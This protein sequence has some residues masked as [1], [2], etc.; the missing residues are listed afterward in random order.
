MK[1]PYIEETDERN[2]QFR[3]QVVREQPFRSTT[4][5]VCQVTD[6]CNVD[7]Q[8]LPCAPLLPREE[9][10]EP[11]VENV[12]VASAPKQKRRRLTKKTPDPTWKKRTR[13]E[14]LRADCPLWVPA[15]LNL[16]KAERS[17]LRSFAASFQKAAAVDFYITKYQCKPM[18]SMTPL[19]QS[20]T[21]GLHR[22]EQQEAE[23]ARDAVAAARRTVASSS[24]PAAET[25][26]TEVSA[27][28]PAASADAVSVP[29]ADDL[30]N[31][32]ED[33]IAKRRKSL[34]ALARRARRVT[35][36]LAS[37][38]N[39]C[40]WLSAAEMV[41]HIL[42]D[43]DCLQTNTNVTIFTRQLQWAFQ[44]CKRIL[45]KQ[46]STDGVQREHR[47]VA[48]VVCNAS[49]ECDG[50][51]GDQSKEDVDVEQMTACTTSTNASDDY[52]HRGSRLRT[53][54]QYVY[55]MHVRRIRLTDRSKTPAANIFFFEPHYAMARTYVQELVLHK[56]SVPT[57]DGFQCPTVQQD[58]EQNALSKALLF[59]PWCC[60]DPMTCG[61][62]L[63]YKHMLLN[64]STQVA[65]AGDTSASSSPAAQRTTQDATSYTFQRAWRLRWA[66]INVLAERAD[67]RQAASRKH[68]VMADTTLFAEVKEPAAEIVV[69]EDVL[70]VVRDWCHQLTHSRMPD[71]GGRIVLAFLDL[72]CKAH[73][74][75][76]SLAEFCAH[77]ARDVVVHMDL[78]AEARAGKKPVRTDAAESDASSDSDSLEERKEP[79]MHL[80]DVGGGAD[81]DD[82]GRRRDAEDDGDGCEEE[83]FAARATFPL[84]TVQEALDVCFQKQHLQA[85]RGKTRKSQAD[86]TLQEIS[87]LYSPALAQTSP[88]TTA[89]AKGFVTGFPTDYKRMLAHQ[90]QYVALAKKQQQRPGGDTPVDDDAMLAQAEVNDEG[91]SRAANAASQWVP[92]PLALQ[93][94]GA[95]AWKLLTD[96]KCTEEQIDAVA[97]LAE[98]ME[99]RFRARPEADR[100]K[101]HLLPVVAPGPQHRAVWLGGGGVGKTMTL[102]EV[103]QPLTETFFG[104]SSYAA[105]AQSNHAAQNLGNRGRTLHAANALLLTSSLK[106][107]RLRL[108]ATSQKKMDFLTG[109]LAVGAID[110]IG[111]VPGDLLHADALRTT[112][113]R[114]LRYN[115][116]PT[117]YMKPSETWGRMFA[118]ILCGDF[119]QLPP[120]PPTASLL[121]ED[122]PKKPQ[123]YEWRQARKLLM[124]MEYVV[125]FRQM[126]RFTDPLLVEIL[127][128]MRT[129]GGKKISDAAWAALGETVLKPGDASDQRLANARH[130][131]EC[132]YEWRHVSFAMHAHARLNAKAE[133]KVLYFVQAVDRPR[134]RITQEEYEAMRA[135]SNI[136]TSAK[137]PGLLPLYV[138]MEMILTSSYLPPRIVR[139]AEVVVVDI[140]LH[141][142]DAARLR[143][144]TLDSSGCVLLQYMPNCVYVRLRDDKEDYLSAGSSASPSGSQSLRGV[145]AVEPDTRE[146]TFRPDATQQDIHARRTQVP[147]LPRKQTTYHG[148]QGKTGD[149]G[150]IVHLTFP[151][152]LAK[153]SVWLAYYVALS[154]PR[155]LAQLLCH[156]KPDRSLIEG[157]PPA[158]L[159]D[160]LDLLF[161]AKIE[162]TKVACAAA[163]R[164]LGWPVRPA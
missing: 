130:W 96:A 63:N 124:D 143:N 112:Y 149:P 158:A 154:R 94:P 32:T 163:R 50:D 3:V 23:E 101:N 47:N 75:Q 54:P 40:F 74:E 25:E 162:R 153:E 119:L 55:R 106:T 36:R 103:V 133:G 68:L 69:G 71:H 52:A 148:V 144:S 28:A 78:A 33:P 60:T 139:G 95:V 120:V 27:S 152:G 150:C 123:S 118:K 164:Y 91:I 117:L 132:A 142:F 30:S 77:V 15:T 41:V 121:A 21:H 114:C 56:I 29:S 65:S 14:K 109:D 126:R 43:G 66:E 85:L 129:P 110:E 146:W 22:L 17:C 53:M 116:D 115:L 87:D 88:C 57:I 9:A 62:V 39:R 93:G 99:K 7:F 90:K 104:P 135:C 107:A 12:P 58:P 70:S 20:M 80:Q 51:E 19:F 4:N 34:E 137:L 24:A 134:R 8:F 76:C 16:T 13:M 127:E 35:I 61:S 89:Q 156:G 136:G 155:S 125:D 59:T 46:M 73:S 160:A 147:L 1:A 44:E 83:S 81:T 82:E 45:N 145:F 2:Q 105:A 84:R 113:G 26:A 18:E 108:D 140:E 151:K 122:T 102:Q 92:I 97:L 131:Y 64:S 49:V 141:P 159:A 67:E 79:T 11:S 86:H 48:A 5:D 31:L 38:A 10:E 100:R 72:Q 157:G 128:A 42:T 37:M 98:P 111:A 6:R 161:S 138:G